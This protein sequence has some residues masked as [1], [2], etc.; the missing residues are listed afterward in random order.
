[1]QRATPTMGSGGQPPSCS[2]LHPHDKD[3]QTLWVTGKLL[4]HAATST[5]PQFHT[6]SQ[7]APAPRTPF[8]VLGVAGDTRAQPQPSLQMPF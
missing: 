8:L 1:M 2:V 5:P 3:F 7:G 6:H 4:R